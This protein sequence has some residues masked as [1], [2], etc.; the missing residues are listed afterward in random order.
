MRTL[1]S[2][3]KLLLKVAGNTLILDIKPWGHLTHDGISLLEAEGLVKSGVDSW[4]G[5]AERQ[6][7][8]LRTVRSID[9]DW[10]SR[11]AE[12]LG[13]QQMLGGR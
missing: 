10:V 6:N 4:F 7:E 2:G 1:H 12:R 5:P 11:E 3:R 8:I 9:R 13:C